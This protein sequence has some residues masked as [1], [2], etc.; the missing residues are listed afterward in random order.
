MVADVAS[1]PANPPLH[2]PHCT[3][4]TCT[5]YMRVC[6]CAPLLRPATALL[7]QTTEEWRGV[8]SSSSSNTQF[9]HFILLRQQNKAFNNCSFVY[10]SVCVADALIN[11]LFEWISFGLRS[12]NVDNVVLSSVREGCQGLMLNGLSLTI[13]SIFRMWDTRLDREKTLLAMMWRRFPS[14]GAG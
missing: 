5:L 7:S 14:T 4:S 11:L 2:Q 1:K 12:D 10:L 3:M 8:S 9:S 13:C 6:L